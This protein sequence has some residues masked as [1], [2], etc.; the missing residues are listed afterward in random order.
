[1]RSIVAASLLSSRSQS[2]AAQSTPVAIS[3]VTPGYAIARVRRLPTPD[4]AAAIVP[5]V[6]ANAGGIT[7]SYLEQVQGNSNY[8]WESDE[9][10]RKLESRM[11]AGFAAVCEIA[12]REQVFLRD[13]AYLIAI[14]RVAR[15]CHERGWV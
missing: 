9:V 4:L 6:L 1:M 15:A 13:A 7:C 10:L 11:A 14:E 2:T 12:D 3:A 8:Y 5:D